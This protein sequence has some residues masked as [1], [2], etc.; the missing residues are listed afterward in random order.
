MNPRESQS[1]SSS[2]IIFSSNLIHHLE[3]THRLPSTYV[4]VRC[5]RPV[6]D[7]VVKKDDNGDGDIHRHGV[8]K[9]RKCLGGDNNDA[10][11]NSTASLCNQPT[12][13]SINNPAVSISS[14]EIIMTFKV[15]NPDGTTRRMTTQ[16][17]R[18]IKYQLNQE[19]KRMKKEV[20]QQKH[21]EGIAL[22]K[23]QKAE[24]NRL[25][26][27]QKLQKL[28]Q[29]QQQDADDGID[30]SGGSNVIKKRSRD[31][32]TACKTNATSGSYQLSSSS[33]G[34]LDEYY[35]DGMNKSAKED[36]SSLKGGK[37]CHL[38]PVM[39]TPA[40]TCIAQDMGLIDCSSAV[41][42]NKEGV[43]KGYPKI[44][45]AVMDPNLS[46]QWATKLQQSMIPIE[47]S[48]A[49]EKI[50]PMAYRVVPQVWKR[51]CPESL[52]TVEEDVKDSSN[53]CSSSKE[54]AKKEEKEVQ[55]ENPKDTVMSGNNR[56]NAT[57]TTQDHH[58]YTCSHMVT[59]RD[60]SLQ[61]DTDTCAIIQ[62]LHQQSKLHITCGATFGCDFLLYDGNR[63]DTH[64]FA[65]LRVCCSTNSMVTSCCIRSNVEEGIQFP[66]PTAYDMYGFVRSMNTARK[67]A[68]LATV[69]RVRQRKQR[70]ND[71]SDDAHD[72]ETIVDKVVIVHLALKGQGLLK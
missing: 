11:C 16:E 12:S 46:S 13:T 37:I 56:V 51:H 14:R 17:K 43:K 61:H 3:T 23:K 27:K 39:L 26:R 4:G 30:G 22:A 38:P 25:K 19:R 66:I 36:A 68:L 65:G 29:Q 6:I 57:P 32:T 35:N 20:V 69:V 64:S 45:T 49:N 33:I 72:D 55:L 47:V 24:R 60:P 48:R 31:S 63:E 42:R 62:H 8:L 28:E 59:L 40:A 44:K 50:R 52:W 54:S 1:H 67:I 5:I 41:P 70:D 34:A 7:G 53:V 2:A 21:E 15:T 71:E 9:K 18:Q 58:E 10:P